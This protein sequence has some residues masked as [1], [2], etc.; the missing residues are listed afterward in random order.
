M[1]LNRKNSLMIAFIII[2]AAMFVIGN[3]AGSNGSPLKKGN[4][5]TISYRG[6]YTGSTNAIVENYS[7]N[8]VVHIPL[9]SGSYNAIINALSAMQ[10]NGSISDY[11]NFGSQINILTGNSTAYQIYSTLYNISN[12]IQAN[13][14]TYV[15]LPSN[16]VLQYYRSSARIY[17]PNKAY[18][19]EGSSIYSIGTRLNVSIQAFVT[20][21]GTLYNNSIRIIPAG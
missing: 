15:S 2:V 17:I 13:M 18:S 6:P 10:S 21:N 20:S 14:T 7:K 1:N 16:L 4:T 3:V 9:S 5:T 19:L 11:N 8:L 12:S